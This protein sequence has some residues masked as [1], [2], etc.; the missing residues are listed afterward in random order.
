MYHKK[1]TQLGSNNVNCERLYSYGNVS[2]QV[3]YFRKIDLA[4]TKNIIVNMVISDKAN[5]LITSPF[6]TSNFCRFKISSM[7]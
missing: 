4:Y 6:E 7:F 2:L 5:V 1:L 3:Y